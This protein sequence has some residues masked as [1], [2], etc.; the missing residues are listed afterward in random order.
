[1]IRSM[2]TTHTNL[3]VDE[4][5]P[6]I[7][8][9][10]SRLGEDLV[11]RTLVRPALRSMFDRVWLKVEGT[12]PH[13]ADGPVIAY[14]NHPSWWD[15][16]L[17]I[18]LH[19]EVLRRRFQNY[20]MMDERQL[21]NYRF[22]TWLGAFSVRLKDHDSAA[23]SVAYVA[24]RLAERRDRCFWIYPQG[25]LTPNDRRPI[26]IYP[27]MARVALQA[28]RALLWPIAM[29]YEFRGE[30]RP[31]AF[32][33]AGPPHVVPATADEAELTAEAQ[34]RLTVAVDAL[35]DD[36]LEERF[37]D[38]QVLL[39]GKPGVNRVFDAAMKYVRRRNARG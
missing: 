9:R 30:Q 14:L 4:T 27:G 7:P 31:E 39:R 18:L 10:H 32:I 29:R 21:R 6:A 2:P 15:G 26:V 25:K 19:R 35:R 34:R 5:L 17:P 28:G 38:Y 16:Y 22:F 13:P 37:D 23:R 12:L 3:P 33:R 11:Y 36:V 20:L 8:A 1:M 24:Q